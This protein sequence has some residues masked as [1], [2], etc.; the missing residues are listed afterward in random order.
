ML[1]LFRT[2]PFASVWLVGFLQEM[3]FFLLV[4]LP[5]RLQQ[6]GLSEAGI[7]LAYSASALSALLL[8][9][10]FGRI[11]DVVHRR[12]VLRTV[13]LANIVCIAA[14]ALI[15]STG[16]LLWTAFLAQRVAQILLFT[17]LLTYAADAITPEHRTEGLAVLGLS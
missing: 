16:P 3:G 5:G 6:L 4:N 13:G 2:P 9:P 12:T 8:R 7:G 14:L 1:R 15:D 17:T 10:Y 11:L